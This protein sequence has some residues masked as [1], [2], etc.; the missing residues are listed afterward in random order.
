ME[1]DPSIVK[2][3]GLPPDDLDLTSEVTTRYNIV[4]GC[5]LALACFV[6]G[7]R[8]H[9]RLSRSKLWWDDYFVILALVSV[10]PSTVV[11]RFG[12]L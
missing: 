12:F 5:M 4:M 10:F 6:V 7:L 8:V 2:I 9:V 1:Y 3:F 11:F